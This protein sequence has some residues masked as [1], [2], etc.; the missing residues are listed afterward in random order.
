MAV[1]V[2]QIGAVD[3]DLTTGSA[4]VLFLL[5]FSPLSLFPPGIYVGL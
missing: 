4:S 3:D 2:K 5:L 1:G